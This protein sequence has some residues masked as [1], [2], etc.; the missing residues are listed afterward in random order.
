VRTQVRATVL[1][2]LRESENTRNPYA[3]RCNQ[4]ATKQ[5]C[6]IKT[7]ETLK[8]Q[9]LEGIK[10]MFATLQP[11]SFAYHARALVK[12]SLKSTVFFDGIL[13]CSRAHV[14]SAKKFGCKVAD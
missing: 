11:I 2:H 8:G 3:T 7:R 10:L 4:S 1:C 13:A 14:C 9:D 6:K 5:G 12:A